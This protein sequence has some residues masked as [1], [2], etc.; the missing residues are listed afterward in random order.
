MNK[1]ADEFFAQNTGGV[2]RVSNIYN[3]FEL[4]DSDCDDLH[5][6][7]NDEEPEKFV[8]IL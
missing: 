1:I 7:W 4:D 3:D 8:D 5:L 6:G 2:A